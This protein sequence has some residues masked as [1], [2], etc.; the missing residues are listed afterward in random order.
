MASSVTVLGDEGVSW[1]YFLFDKEAK[2]LVHS[3]LLRLW[4]GWVNARLT[5]TEED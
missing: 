1:V 2:W 3:P 5:H 4:L